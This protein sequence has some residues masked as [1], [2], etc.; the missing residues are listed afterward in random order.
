MYQCSR[1]CR[2]L[3]T[4]CAHLQG[5]NFFSAD[6]VAHGGNLAVGFDNR[7]VAAGDVSNGGV[8]LWLVLRC[9]KQTYLVKYTYNLAAKKVRLVAK[10][11]AH[12]M[13]TL[14]QLECMMVA[15]VR[16]MRSALVQL[17]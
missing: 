16:I 15:L 9:S 3:R 11:G 2:L 6:I 10:R 7:L 13:H 17:C 4:C 8:P 14:Q 5:C 1:C 12:H